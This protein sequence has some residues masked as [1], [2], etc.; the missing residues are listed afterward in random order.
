MAASAYKFLGLIIFSTMFIGF[1]KTRIRIQE[2]EAGSQNKMIS[3]FFN[4]VF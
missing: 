4:S 2:P 3:S 1:G